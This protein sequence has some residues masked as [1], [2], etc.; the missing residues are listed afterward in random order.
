M[1]QWCLLYVN[2]FVYQCV[3]LRWLIDYLAC[4]TYAPTKSYTIGQHTYWTHHRCADVSCCVLR[5]PRKLPFYLCA[6]QWRCRLQTADGTRESSH[7]TLSHIVSQLPIGRLTDAC[8]IRYVY[9]VCAFCVCILH[10]WLSNWLQCIH[11][12]THIMLPW[13]LCALR[14]T[15][16]YSLQLYKS[17]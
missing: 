6:A 7:L 16:N 15:V 1:D 3:W 14:R 12:S 5:C 4:I 9:R 11:T 13:T 8:N 17:I 10:G 2:K